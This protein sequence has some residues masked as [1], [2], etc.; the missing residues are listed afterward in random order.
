MLP[1]SVA[2]FDVVVT[3]CPSSLIC[4]TLSVVTDLSL[5][6]NELNSFSVLDIFLL[7]GLF[8]WKFHCKKFNIFFH[9]IL[10]CVLKMLI[11]SELRVLTWRKYSQTCIKRSPLGQRESGLIRQVTS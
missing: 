1:D 7:S 6:V 10:S 3:I 2:C 4:Q 11:N 8:H 5:H 9:K